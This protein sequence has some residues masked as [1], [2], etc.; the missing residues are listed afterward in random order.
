MKDINKSLTT[1]EWH[2]TYETVEVL[3]ALV[4]HGS[5]QKISPDLYKPLKSKSISK[6]VGKFIKKNYTNHL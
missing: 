1:Y 2:R 3:T 4:A 6:N 5:K